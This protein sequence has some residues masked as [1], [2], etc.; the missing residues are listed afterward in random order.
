MRIDDVL[1]RI[2]GEFANIQH[3]FGTSRRFDSEAEK[4]SSQGT[5]RLS[6]ILSRSTRG[7]DGT[8]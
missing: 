3:S 4:F 8:M 7:E 1:Q 5:F 2:Q 6:S